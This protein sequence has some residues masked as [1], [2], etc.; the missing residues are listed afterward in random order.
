MFVLLGLLLRYS[1]LSAAAAELLLSGVVVVA[2]G[3]TAFVVGGTADTKELV[4][5]VVQLGWLVVVA[6]CESRYSEEQHFIAEL[7][8]P[9]FSLVS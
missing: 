7:I 5:W 8:Y 2:T 4:L 1:S 9:A 6:C 3:A